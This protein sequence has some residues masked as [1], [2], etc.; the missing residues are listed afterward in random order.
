VDQTV[1]LFHAGT[2]YPAVERWARR[3]NS[4]LSG[5][6][7][8][9][10]RVLE[11]RRNPRSLEY[12][13]R[14]AEEIFPGFDPREMVVVGDD[15]QLPALDWSAI[16]KVVLLWP[17]ANGTGWARVVRHILRRKR[18]NTAV[19]VLNGRR[20]FFVLNRLTWAGFAWRG[21]LEKTL[22]AEILFM[23]AFIVLSPWLTLWD[24]VRGRR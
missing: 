24:V 11:Y 1:F 13:Q 19:F 20:R 6:I 23:L 8:K 16:H 12:M 10:A 21:F 18:A 5:P 14:L 4:F 7:L 9:M 17:D 2:A 15:R 22:A 3:R